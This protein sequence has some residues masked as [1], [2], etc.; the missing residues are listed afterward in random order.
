MNKHIIPINRGLK[1]INDFLE[2]T[3]RIAVLIRD[4]VS[5]IH[6]IKST[7]QSSIQ[8]TQYQVLTPHNQL[9]KLYIATFDTFI[10]RIYGGGYN[11]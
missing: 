7:Y 11:A 2:S 3:L 1:F 6:N 10:S 4:S 8:A 9:S 5:S